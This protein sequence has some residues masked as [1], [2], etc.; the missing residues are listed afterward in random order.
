[1][2]KN[3][4]SFFYNNLVTKYKWQEIDA[5]SIDWSHTRVFGHIQDPIERRH[6]GILEHL[7]INGC[8]DLLET[9]VPFQQLIKH[10]PALDEHTASLSEMFGQVM[11]AI[12]WI[13]LSSDHKETVRQTEKLISLTGNRR[14]AH[15][16]LWDW[17]H[18]RPADPRMIKAVT[19]LRHLWSESMA[20]PFSRRYF[21]R[22]QALFKAV[23]DSFNAFGTT[24]RET[25]WLR[26]RG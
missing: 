24:W 26:H 11:W 10:V 17:S 1:M 8:L 12:D 9:N 13:P 23:T 6:K 7:V 22:D 25:S 14:T 3:A 2:L 16:G 21:D 19:I 18:A 4:S 20:P 5:H 15:L